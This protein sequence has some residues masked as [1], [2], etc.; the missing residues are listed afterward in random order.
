MYVIGVSNV[1]GVEAW[2][3]YAANYPHNIQMVVWPDISVLLTNRDTGKWL[4]QPPWLSRWRPYPT[5]VTTNIAANMWSGYI[6][7]APPP[8]YSF[9]IPIVTNLL[10][11][12]NSTYSHLAD[13]FTSL[14]GR[15]ERTP[16]RT[17]FYIPPYW[18][19]TLNPRLRFA[20]VDTDTQRIVDYVNLADNNVLNITNALTTDGYCGDPYAVDGSSGSMW[21]TERM[22]GAG[23]GANSV[24]TFGINNQI[25]ASLGHPIPHLDWNN[26]ATVSDIPAATSFF[27]DQFIPGGSLRSSNT[28]NAPYQP[29]R[30]IFLTTS[31]Q[32]NDP[33]VHYTVGDLMDLQHTNVVVDN[34]SS[35]VPRP[36]DNL[37]KLNTRYSPWGGSPV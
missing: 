32:A 8:S 13:G 15:F 28:F 14:T 19:L 30:N 23:P 12:T 37:G 6:Q 5:A 20:L 7:W 36:T 17:N 29:F 35:T 3:S 34:F 22:Y 21:C 4:N 26:A 27:R 24:A 2:N 10:F 9:Q 11:L 18:E 31:W 33:L 16:A 25:E 1:V